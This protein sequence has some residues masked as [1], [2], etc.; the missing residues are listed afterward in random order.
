MFN[1]KQYLELAERLAKSGD[2]AELRSAISRAYYAAHGTAVNWVV[3]EGKG[4]SPSPKPQHT[5]LWNIMQE[6]SR[7]EAEE[8]GEYGHAL[9]RERNTADYE[10][11]FRKPEWRAA[12]A[13]LRA[14]AMLDSL[15]TL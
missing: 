7:R 13:I 15:A 2:E 12:F 11:R 8:I 5:T 1:W 10:N 14:R 6:D 4:V 9:R 3:A